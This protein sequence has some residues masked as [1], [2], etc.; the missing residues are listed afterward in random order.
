MK[1]YKRLQVRIAS[2]M[3][4]C[5]LLTTTVIVA[6]IVVDMRRQAFSERE[7]ALRDTQNYARTLAQQ[8]A[9]A[10][11]AEMETAMDTARTLAQSLQGVKNPDIG[12]QIDRDQVNGLLKTVLSE[13]DNFVGIG[14]AWEPNAFDELDSGYANEPGHDA[15]GRFIPYWSRSENDTLTLA[16]LENYATE[17]KGEYYFCPKQTKRE[18][19]IDPYLYPVQ[20]KN[21]FMTTL[22]APIIFQDNFYGVITVDM[23][24]AVLQHM[25]DTLPDL[26]GGDAQFVLLSHNG[27]IVAAKNQPQLAGQM[28]DTLHGG[29]E[30]AENQA[31]NSDKSHE[32]VH[33][34]LL[35]VIQSGEESVMLL[36]NA[37]EVF[38]PIHIGQSATPWI[39]NINI[40]RARI[41]AEADALLKES[42]QKTFVLIG[43]SAG[44]ALLAL[45]AIFLLARSLSIPIIQAITATE[46]LSE[47]NLDVRIAMTRSDEIGRFQ[48]VVNVMIEKLRDVTIS[49]QKA[50]F[51]VA[52]GSQNLS[53]SAQAMSQGASQQAAAAEQASSSIEQMAANIRQNAENALQTEKLAIKSAEDARASGAAVLETVSAM[54][55]ISKRV[56]IIEDIARQ[57]RLLSLNATIEAA[58]A[59]EHGKGFAV[60]AAEVRSLAERSQTASEEINHLAINSISI[61]EQAGNMLS[62]LVPDIQKTSE[63]VQEITAASREQN[64]GTEQINR[65]IQQLD[66]IVQQN[67]AMS[68]EVASTAEELA[69]Q[70]GQLRAII[71]FFHVPESMES[72]DAPIPDAVSPRQPKSRI[73]PD[74]RPDSQ[75]NT[76]LKSD[77]ET[78]FSAMPSIAEDEHDK[79]FERY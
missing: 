53:S 12:L 37:L 76:R 1:F 58:R 8:Y 61:A 41:T 70:A 42:R 26:Y 35:N 33:T 54:H 73:S 31:N 24:L 79:D 25:I 36:E 5:L 29:H 38:T 67:A 52:G 77:R 56:S 62:R 22:T 23:R 18:C 11:K 50:A 44:C 27:T 64:A 39:V 40:P 14:T 69:A 16:P 34:H 15:T 20:G 71:G 21:I 17:G 60:V 68:E 51:Q 72:F 13:N 63:L 59:Q 47:G 57:T 4:L 19:V 6:Y 49:I 9:N 75:K 32:D 3:G 55:E 43:I 74:A 45:T 66:Q 46:K 48:T 28:I 65:A 7:K 2:W 30:H 78:F 10:I